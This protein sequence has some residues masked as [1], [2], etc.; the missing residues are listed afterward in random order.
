MLPEVDFDSAPAVAQFVRAEFG[1]LYPGA[2]PKVLLRLFSDVEALF[3]GRT[4]DFAPIDLKYHNF[5]HTLMATVCMAQIL[6]G[7]FA[8]DGDGKLSPRDFELAIAGVLLHDSGYLKLKSDTKGTGAKYTYCHIL[9]SCAFAAS[10]LP[11]LGATD[12]EIDSVLSAI[13]CTGPHS[14]IGRLH[15]RNS[16]SRVVGCALATADYLGQLADPHYPD[17]L[18]ELYAE[19][20]E[21]DDYANVPQSKRAFKSEEDLFCRTPGFWVHFV[22]PKLETDFQSVYRYLEKPL[23]SGRNGYLA[24]VEEN[25]ARIESRIAEIKSAAR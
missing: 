10:Y 20:C 4:P 24:A 9:R 11:Q 2:S 1:K 17:K 25:F 16:V 15:F 22:K 14:E 8:S 23:G 13:N 19:F 18:G 21:S 12:I 6:E 5:R 3:E 7:E